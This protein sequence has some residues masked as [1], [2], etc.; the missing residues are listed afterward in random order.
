MPF[1]PVQR[2]NSSRSSPF[3]VLIHWEGVP[4]ISQ[5]GKI[6]YYELQ[7][8]FTDSSTQI[9]QLSSN[10]NWT[11]RT[12]GDINYFLLTNLWHTV[13]FTVRVTAHNR[14]GSSP[15]AMTIFQLIEG[16]LC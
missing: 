16:L 10:F 1:E 14:K 13:D 11:N 3:S 5:N 6:L 12:D 15:G 7:T 9:P 4:S 2:L 8:T